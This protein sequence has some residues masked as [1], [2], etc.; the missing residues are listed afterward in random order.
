MIS[1]SMITTHPTI[2][3]PNFDIEEDTMGPG[4]LLAVSAASI[5][6]ATGVLAHGGAHQEPIKLPDDATW[7]ER[8]MAGLSTPVHIEDC[9]LILR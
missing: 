5:A 6:L 9:W 7:A 4:K 1:S 2:Q 8:H 3:D